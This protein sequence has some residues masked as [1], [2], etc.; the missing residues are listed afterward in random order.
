MQNAVTS[1]T[2]HAVIRFLPSHW[3][4]EG[5]QPSAAVPPLRAARRATAHV[6]TRFSSGAEHGPASKCARFGGSLF[7]IPLTAK[8]V[9]GRYNFLTSRLF[10][11]CLQHLFAFTFKG[12]FYFPKLDRH[13]AEMS[14]KKNRS[15]NIS[16]LFSVRQRLLVLTSPSHLP[17]KS[18]LRIIYATCTAHYTLATTEHPWLLKNEGSRNPNHKLKES[19][20][21]KEKRKKIQQIKPT[22]KY[23]NYVT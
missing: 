1:Q 15:W 20:S 8:Q 12:I 10:S 22:I 17:T 11:P 9:C 6:A 19:V 23:G 5:R 7:Q 13:S 21:F 3:S 14:S 16:V 18:T 4:P 2:S